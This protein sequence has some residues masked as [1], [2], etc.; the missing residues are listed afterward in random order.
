VIC[1]IYARKSNKPKKKTSKKADTTA[2][3]PLQI[4]RCREY[5]AARGWTISERHV[6]SDLAISG[7]EFRKRPGLKSLLEAI[8]S[9]PPF[10]ALLV[11]ETSRLGREQIETAYALK[12]ITDEGVRVF[13]VFDDKEITLNSAL[14]KFT[15]GAKGFTDESE[16]ESAGTRS[17]NV[18]KALAEQGLPTGGKLYG[19]ENTLDGQRIIKPSEAEVVKRIFTLRAK[20]HG[21]Y[22]IAR[23]I[24]QDGSASPRESKNP[25]TGEPV[26]S[27]AQIGAILNN[28]TYHGVQVWGRLHRTKKGGTSVTIKSPEAIVRK[29][30]PKLRIIEEPLWLT[31]QEINQAARDACWRAPDGTLRSRPT[32]GKGKHLLTPI[33]ACGL[34]GGSMH[35][36]RDNTRKREFLICTNLH[37]YGKR[38]CTNTSQMPVE[39]AER[40]IITKFEGALVADVVIKKVNELLDAQRAAAE[41]PAPLK[42]EATKLRAEIGRLVDALAGGGDTIEEVRGGIATRKAKLTQ[43]E[44][45]LAGIGIEPIDLTAFNKEVTAALTDL[46]LHLRKHPSTA[47]AVLRK[48][49][50]TRLTITPMPGG[51]WEINGMADYTEVLKTTGF[52]QAKAAVEALAQLAKSGP[53]SWRRSRSST[54]RIST[55][56]R[57]AAPGSRARTRATASR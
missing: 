35:H 36:R 4:Q 19:Y 29:E 2:S 47:Q 51:G 31:V 39:F 17:R 43:I 28:E 9:K 33:L 6:F 37:R 24:E 30:V 53:R 54:A 42:A 5:A 23:L 45:R 50:P 32:V 44:A 12:Q 16:R 25:D 14:E 48:I 56:R 38:K 57:S 40:F 20:G 15:H 7:A 27:P 1:A 34:C 46:K 49:C 8:E 55:R 18:M 13:T 10:Q 41:D 26:W 52:S 21:H 11:T 3:V 22:K